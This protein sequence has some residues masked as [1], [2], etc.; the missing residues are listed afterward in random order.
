MGLRPVGLGQERGG[1]K[2][3]WTTRHASLFGGPGSARRLR[4]CARRAKTSARKTGLCAGKAENQSVTEGTDA[5]DFSARC[6]GNVRDAFGLLTEDA[7][8]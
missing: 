3:R 2:I 6:S 8:P 7:H 5:R 1:Q 4:F